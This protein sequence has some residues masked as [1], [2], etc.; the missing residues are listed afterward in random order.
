M[1]HQQTVGN[2][3]SVLCDRPVVM[4][5]PTRLPFPTF[6]L[7]DL[8][9]LPSSHAHAWG[10]HKIEG[11]YSCPLVAVFRLRFPGLTVEVFWSPALRTSRQR[12]AWS[13]V[14]ILNVLHSLVVLIFI[15]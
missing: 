4:L 11:L 10:H 8:L 3:W 2:L 6:P 15:Q 9:R 7:N 1:T 5:S 14:V 13:T 12:T